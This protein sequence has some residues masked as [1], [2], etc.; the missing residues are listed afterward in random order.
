LGNHPDERR[1]S[2]PNG[3]PSNREQ[4]QEMKRINQEPANGI[5]RGLQAPVQ[6]ARRSAEPARRF[7]HGS[8]SDR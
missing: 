3:R 4:S 1:N 8:F 5:G 7:Q 2:R 6:I